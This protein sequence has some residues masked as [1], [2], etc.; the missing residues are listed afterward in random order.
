MAPS[1]TLPCC[2]LGQDGTVIVH[3]VRRGQ[4]LRT[5][6]PPGDSCVP[7]VIS[8]LRVGMEGHIVVQTSLGEGSHRKVLQYVRYSVSTNT[9]SKRVFFRPDFTRI[10]ILL[11]PT[12]QVLHPCL[13]SKLLSAV[14]LHPGG[15]GDRSPPGVRTHHPGDRGGQTPH[16]RVMQVKALRSSLHVGCSAAYRV[17]L[18]LKVEF[19]VLTLLWLTVWMLRSRPWPWRFLWGVCLSPKSAATSSWA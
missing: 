16:T 6:H 3:S 7:A 19:L 14:L 4:F 11:I 2:S 13:L 10:N 1:L 12:G 8:E 18:S 9:H 15:E 17:P 5:L